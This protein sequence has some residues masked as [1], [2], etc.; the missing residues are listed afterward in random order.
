MDLQIKNI[1]LDLPQCLDIA[2]QNNIKMKIA[3][4]TMEAS[5]WEYRS[6]L[7]EFLPDLSSTFRVQQLQGTFLVGNVAPD[8]VHEIPIFFS[9]LAEYNALDNNKIFFEARIKNLLKNKS[10]IA[11]IL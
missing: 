10:N 1:V 3:R 7:A 2:L 8:L 9:I 5:K 6:K 11:I 4:N